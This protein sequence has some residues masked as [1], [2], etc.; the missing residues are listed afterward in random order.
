MVADFFEFDGMDSIFIG[1]N[2]PIDAT[3]QFIKDKD[4]KY[5]ALS[6]TLTLNL[7]NLH[8]LIK[9]NEKCKK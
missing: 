9:K 3:I 2:T 7:P 1:S 5:F 8:N 6:T 4:F